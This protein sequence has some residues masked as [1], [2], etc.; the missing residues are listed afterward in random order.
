MANTI[1]IQIILTI[2]FAVSVGLFFYQPWKES[3]KYY[4]ILVSL[5]SL[6]ITILI[7]LI[8]NPKITSYKSIKQNPKLAL[9]IDNSESIP[10]GKRDHLLQNCLALIENNKDL[11]KKFDIVKYSFGSKLS[12]HDSLTLRRIRQ[13]LVKA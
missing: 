1:Y 13:K 2:L 8:L 12:I 10:L 5:R 3:S 4:W 6:T 7:L 9:L 11:K